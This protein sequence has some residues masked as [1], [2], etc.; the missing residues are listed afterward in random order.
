[1]PSAD[2][3]ALHLIEAASLPAD[4]SVR[5]KAAYVF[6]VVTFGKYFSFCSFV[7]KSKIPYEIKKNVGEIVLS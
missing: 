7:P 4:G 1:M 3:T 2:L 5:A 6:P